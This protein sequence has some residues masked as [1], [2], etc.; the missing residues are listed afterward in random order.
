MSPR[1]GRGRGGDD[2]GLRFI[3]L[4]FFSRQY[5]SS[6]AASARIQA[7]LVELPATIASMLVIAIASTVLTYLAAVARDR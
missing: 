3:G 4:L 7:G 1:R 5:Y 2:R 6:Y